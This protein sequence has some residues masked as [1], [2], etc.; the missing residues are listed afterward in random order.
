M[1]HQRTVLTLLQRDA[2]AAAA[3]AR[4]EEEEA[5]GTRGG[6]DG[7]GGGRAAQAAAGGETR[8]EG[9]AAAAA[10]VGL[11]VANGEQSQVC[12][13]PSRD[14]WS[15]RLITLVGGE[16]PFLQPHH[17]RVAIPQVITLLGGKSPSSRRPE[18]RAVSTGEPGF[19]CGRVTTLPWPPYASSAP[20]SSPS[21]HRAIRWANSHRIRSHPC[22]LP[23]TPRAGASRRARAA[24]ATTTNMAAAAGAGARSRGRRRA[25]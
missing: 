10:A 24:S 20:W 25:L 6:D 11:E 3:A 16:S 2:A 23:L 21:L 7:G 12:R 9:S 17:R 13:S 14:E 8:A 1:F 22:T 5:Q 18:T 4:A 19:Q 15:E